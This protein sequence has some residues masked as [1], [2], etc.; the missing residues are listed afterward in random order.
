MLL[1]VLAVI[2]TLPLIQMLMTMII[3]TP[4]SIPMPMLIPNTNANTNTKAKGNVNNNT[5]V[6]A[7]QIKCIVAELV[8][9]CGANLSQMY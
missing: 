8:P 6:N 5:N 7:I 4:N 1:V 2:S 3:Q 9:Y